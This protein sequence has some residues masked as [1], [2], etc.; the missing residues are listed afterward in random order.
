MHNIEIHWIATEVWMKSTLVENERRKQ[1]TANI[2]F[3][4][5]FSFN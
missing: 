5:L 1:F 3:F 4:S 2:C